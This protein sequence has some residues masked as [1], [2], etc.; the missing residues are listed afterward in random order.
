MDLLFPD[1]SIK[2]RL[3]QQE[4]IEKEKNVHN[5]EFPRKCRINRRPF[6]GNWSI[7]L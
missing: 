7:Y 3:Q 5:I 1:N 4:E 2:S 6:H